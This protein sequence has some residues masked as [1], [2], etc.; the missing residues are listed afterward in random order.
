MNESLPGA[1]IRPA[2]EPPA[3]ADAI[4]RLR[5][6]RLVALPTETVYGLAARTMDPHAIARIYGT[7]GRPS[8]NPLIAHASSVAM[9]R[10]LAATWPA[11]ADRLARTLWPGPLTIVLPRSREVP[12][13]AAGGRDSIGIRIPAHPVA[14]ELIHRLGEPV[15]APSANRSGSLSPTEARHVMGD[16]VDQDLLV[17]DGGPS[18]IGL[19]STVVD[20]RGD[21]PTVLRPGAVSPARLSAILGFPVA[22][23]TIDRQAD[24]P[25]TATLHYAPATPSRLCTAEEAGGRG[26]AV[27]SFGLLGGPPQ[28]DRIGWLRLDVS[29]DPELAGSLLYAALHAADVAGCDRIDIVSPP[30]TEEWIAIHDR[31]RRATAA[32]DA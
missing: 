23:P 5:A 15:S 3:I 29:D 7:K 28:A 2:W 27:I 13:I 32:A 31:L 6:G 18:R 17:L 1:I 4:V 22:A 12:A 19:E 30:E 16:F 9:A 10:T 24:G 25:G 11:T 20:L 26:V 14:L 8:D 21:Q